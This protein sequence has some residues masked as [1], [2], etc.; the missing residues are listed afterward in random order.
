MHAACEERWVNI[1]QEVSWGLQPADNVLYRS[2]SDAEHK[3]FNWIASSVAILL[4]VLTGIAAIAAHRAAV[5][6]KERD[7]AKMLW[8]VLLLLSA[9]A[10]MVM[11]RPSSFF[12]MHLP[13]LRFV[14]FPL[15]WN[16]IVAV[17]YAY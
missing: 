14:Q 8:R 11:V 7:Q 2:I 16:A 13:K 10:A 6:E 4:L 3:A 12:C 1:S 9:V 15:G 5:H 17:P